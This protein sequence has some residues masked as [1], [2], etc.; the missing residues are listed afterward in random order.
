MKAPYALAVAII[1]LSV[2]PALA[3]QADEPG[4]GEVLVTGT[5]LNAGFAQQDR[6]V[7]GL[8]R[9][10]D[11]AVTYLSISS[12]TRDE[13]TRKQEIRTVLLTAIDHAKAAGLELVSGNFQL[14]PVTRANYQELPFQWAGRVDT[15]KIDLRIKIKLAGSASA[16][17]KRLTDFIKSIPGSG[18]AVVETTG[19]LA[20][21][22]VNPDQY[23]DDIVRLVAGDAKHNAGIFGPDFAF[24]ITGIDGQISWSQVSSTDVFLYLPYRYTIVPK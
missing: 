12:D 9:Q 20:L 4:L 3:Q 17:S 13:A 19:G 23:R 1:A 18:R 5:R 14:I 6:P 11:A 16:A 24:N 10:A 15:S 22:I 7:V 2:A 21:T 8:R